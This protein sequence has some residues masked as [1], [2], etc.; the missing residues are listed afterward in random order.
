[1][2]VFQKHG[3]VSFNS[4]LTNNVIIFSKVFDFEIFSTFMQKHLEQNLTF[5][6]TNNIYETDNLNIK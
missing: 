5:Q 6:N 2:Y 3:S 1:M 4:R